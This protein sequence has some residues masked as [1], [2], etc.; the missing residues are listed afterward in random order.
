MAAYLM[1]IFWALLVHIGLALVGLLLIYLVGGSESALSTLI[2][3]DYADRPEMI[4]SIRADAV[5]QLFRWLVLSLAASWLFASAWLMSA[6]RFM[7]SGPAEGTRRQGLWVVLLLATIAVTTW[8]GW[9]LAYGRTVVTE[10]SS[11]TVT[12]GTLIVAVSTLLGYF[13][14]TGMNVKATMR[15]SVPLGGIL[16]SFPGT[17]Q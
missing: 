7:P 2:R 4:E 13:L 1:K 16:P 10:L 6:Q 15:P 5:A 11:G 12:A 14:A 9:S 17:R 8:L 3:E